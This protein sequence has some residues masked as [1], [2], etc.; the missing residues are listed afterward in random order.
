M[1][2]KTNS[3]NDKTME[4]E[5]KNEETVVFEEIEKLAFRYLVDGDWQ[6]TIEGE[7]LPR[8]LE[9][10]VSGIDWQ[11]QIIIGIEVEYVPE[12]T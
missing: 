7:Q 8:A 5:N 3:R 12:Q 9:C 1:N 4:D 6:D 2:S 11:R 10:T